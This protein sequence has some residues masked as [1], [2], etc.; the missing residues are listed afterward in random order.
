MNF[1]ETLVFQALSAK[2]FCSSCL[3][4][5]FRPWKTSIQSLTSP[6]RIPLCFL[7]SWPIRWNWLFN[8]GS[9]LLLASEDAPSHAWLKYLPLPWVDFC[10]NR[11]ATLPS[12]FLNWETAALVCCPWTL[13][14]PSWTSSTMTKYLLTTPID[15]SSTSP[16][17]PRHPP[18]W[19]FCNNSIPIS[20]T[21]PLFCPYWSLQT[22]F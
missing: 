7:N 15:H 17:T 3:I 6:I 4:H 20:S 5:Q 13:S 22:L 19:I 18:F 21:T 14:W 12:T 16:A 8:R 9:S 2:Y 1:R 10:R 11:W